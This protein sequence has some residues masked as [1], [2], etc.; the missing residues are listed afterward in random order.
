M[1]STTS[2]QAGQT[3]TPGTNESNLMSHLEAFFEGKFSFVKELLQ[4]ARRAGADRIEILFYEDR[5]TLVVKDNGC[6]IS[7]WSPLVRLCE[8]GWSQDVMLSDKPFG[9]GTLSY[10]FAASRVTYSSGGKQL[11]LS[12]ADMADRSA[13]EVTDDPDSPCIGT[14]VTLELHSKVTDAKCH[15]V[16]STTLMKRASMPTSALLAEI[17]HNCSGFPVPVRFNELLVPRPYAVDQMN[18]IDTAIGKLQDFRSKTEFGSNSTLYLQGL[19]LFKGGSWYQSGYIVHLDT[20]QFTARMP[21]RCSLRD[22]NTMLPI[23]RKEIE[24][25]IRKHL[26]QLSATMDSQQFVATYASELA[27]FGCL[28]LLN[29]HPYLPTSMLATFDDATLDWHDKKGFARKP[30]AIT[31]SQR[32]LM[33]LGSRLW[34]NESQAISI[35]AEHF[36][37]DEEHL[38]SRRALAAAIGAVL[39]VGI[40]DQGHWIHRL[41]LDIAECDVQYQVVDAQN[42]GEV[43]VDYTSEFRDDY[44]DIE[45]CFVRAKSIQMQVLLGDEIKLQHDFDALPMAAYHVLPDPAWHIERTN[46]AIVFTDKCNTTDELLFHDCF[47]RFLDDRDRFSE[48]FY[49]EVAEIWRKT[50]HRVLGVSLFTTARQETQYVVS[51]N[52]HGK[53]VVLVAQAA[54]VRPQCDVTVLDFD[55]ATAWLLAGSALQVPADVLRLQVLAAF[56][57]AARQENEVVQT[58]TNPD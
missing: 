27:K 33:D 10:L 4:N 6:G 37:D 29:D 48:E 8:S 23:I 31:V 15:E 28:H 22:E 18:F 40:V 26:Q 49:D 42:T 43:I 56:N 19:P 54:P 3:V 53:A 9:M 20:A 24:A 50:I 41:G 5:G 2:T 25:Q 21:D 12:L 46:M 13:L 7:D 39:F 17:E 52:N 1:E 32:E 35:D 34:R 58:A 45:V 30:S 36:H 38:L 57:E 55:N 51:A 44:N 14:S 16:H 47:C 11:R